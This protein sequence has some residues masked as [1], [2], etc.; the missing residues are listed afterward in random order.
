M[1]KMGC[2]S[3]KCGIL[4][5]NNMKYRMSDVNL[6]LNAADIAAFLKKDEEGSMEPFLKTEEIPAVRED[7]N[8]VVLV[9]KNFEDEVK[10]KNVL[11]FF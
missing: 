3:E 5:R 11:V 10:G 6:S 9:G 4:V 2:A 7:E 8:A 1:N